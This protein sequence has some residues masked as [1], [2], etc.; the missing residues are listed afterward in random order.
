MILVWMWFR[1][2]IGHYHSWWRDLSAH[3][4][5]SEPLCKERR[6]SY[7]SPMCRMM[8]TF[9]VERLSHAVLLSF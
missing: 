8:V 2:L 6:F 7:I 5:C 3:I 4:R 9:V 1:Y